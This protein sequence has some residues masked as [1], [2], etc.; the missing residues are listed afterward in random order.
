VFRI[1]LGDGET[2]TIREE[3]YEPTMGLYGVGARVLAK[4]NESEGGESLRAL[5]DGGASE[6]VWWSLLD[7]GSLST[8]AAGERAIFVHSYE[9]GGILRIEPPPR[10]HQDQPSASP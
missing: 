1:P 9:L 2:T 3:Q 10:A 4:I 8:V 5:D 6:L 7:G